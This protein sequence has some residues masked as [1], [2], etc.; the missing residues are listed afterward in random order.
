MRYFID[1]EFDG[2]GGAL[3]SVA[4]VR[5]DGES[6]HVRAIDAVA[7]DPWVIKN[8]VPLLMKHP[9]PDTGTFTNNIGS[10]L[11]RFLAKDAGEIT[12]IADSPVDIGRFCQV[13]MTDPEGEW[14]GSSYNRLFFE[15]QNVDCYPTSLDGAIQHNAWWDAM[16]LREKLR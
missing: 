8:V 13:F 11:R 16:A 3:L 7:R 4:M 15:V 2:H 6:L 14:L 12:I 1:T 9:G 5:E 10:V